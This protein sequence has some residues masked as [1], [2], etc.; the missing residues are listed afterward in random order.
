[1]AIAVGAVFALHSAESRADNP[2]CAVQ[3]STTRVMFANHGPVEFG[4]GFTG[5][6]GGSTLGLRYNFLL[7]GSYDWVMNGALTARWPP[8]MRVSAMGDANGGRLTV[9]Y[10]LRLQFW[11]SILGTE[12]MIPVPVEVGV[13]RGEIGTRMFTPWAWTGTDTAVT[14]TAHERELRRGTVNILSRDVDWVVYASYEM[15]TSVRTREISFPQAMTS[16]TETNPEADVAPTANG[17]MD[18]PARWAGALRYVGAVRLRFVI[19]PRMPI[20]VPGTPICLSGP[21]NINPDPIPFASATEQQMSVDRSVRLSLPGIASMP[22]EVNFGN[23]RLGLS[24]REV[25]NLQNVGTTLLLATPS[26][27]ADSQFQ[28]AT[29][30]L[31]IPGRTNR[32]LSVRF[33]PDR[34]GAF[35]TDLVIPSS[36]P[37]IPEFRV[38]LRGNGVDTN[39]PLP[40]DAGSAPRDASVD[41][42]AAL[43][44]DASAPEGDGGDGTRFIDDTAGCA[45]HTQPRGRSGGLGVLLLLGAALAGRRRR[46]L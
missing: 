11:L 3:T 1:M 19:T 24:G 43:S 44:D 38:H 41:R 33:V 6:A 13:D 32:A 26:A 29:D 39:T 14:I 42:D 40:T 30:P 15:T 16:I 27:P 9:Q 4:P 8:A 17:D 23:V 31:C 46:T 2:M 7:L 25:L 34:V 5:M 10:G 28:V 20:C 36:A 35:E 12:V 37:S 22:I 18:M 21:Q 45:C